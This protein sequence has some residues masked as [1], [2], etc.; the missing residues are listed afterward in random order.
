VPTRFVSSARELDRARPAAF[1]ARR[2]LRRAALTVLA[3]RPAEPRPGVRIAHYHYVFDD[4]CEGF[5]RQLD[6]LAEAY[7]PVSLT[8]AVARLRDGRAAG[9][10]IVVTFDDGFRNQVRNAAPLLAER[11]FRACFFLVTGLVSAD[12]SEAERICRGRLHLPR[13]IEPMTWQEA[14]RLIELGHEVGSHTRSHPDLTRVAPAQLGEELVT[15]KEEL[16]RRLGGGVAHFSA[17]YGEAHRFSTAVSSAAQEA[18]YESC[19]TAQRGRNTSAD[20]IYALRRDHL[21][22]SWPVADVRYFMAR[23]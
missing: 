5:A 13:P 16:E 4:D 17:P 14:A 8:E 7:Q 18:G 3:R 22:A 19:A 11:G 1:R 15:S 9:R 2:S 20:G 21:E 10:E 6:F 23:A 12:P